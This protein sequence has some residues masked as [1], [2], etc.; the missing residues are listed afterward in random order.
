[1]KVLLVCKSKIMENLGLMYLSAVVKQGGHECKIVDIDHALQMAT[2]WQPHIIGYSIMTGDQKRFAELNTKIKDICGGLSIAGGP[3]VSFFGNDKELLGFN[4]LIKGEGE[5]NLA[6]FLAYPVK[7]NSIDDL[8]WPDRTDFPDMK[9]RDFISSRGC[10]HNC[11]YCFNDKWSKLHPQFERIRT[12]DAKDVCAEIKS[13]N[14]EFAYFQDSCFALKMDWLENF[15]DHYCGIPYHCTFAP[16][17]LR[18]NG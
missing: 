6:I 16:N 8:P 15:A 14:P 4:F 13:V 3:H 1:M 5:Q 9:I 17:R 2:A 12:R 7:Y 18:K 10:P 11:A